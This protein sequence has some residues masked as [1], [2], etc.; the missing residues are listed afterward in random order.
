M[1]NRISSKLGILLAV[2]GVFILTDRGAAQTET[3][4]YNFSASSGA[5]PTG[6]SFDS[7]GNLYGTTIGEGSHDFGTVFSLAPDSSGGWTETALYRFTG[8]EDGR[9]PQPRLAFDSAGNIYGVTKQGGVVSHAC[10]FYGCGVVFRL[11]PSTNGW[12]YSVLYTFLG[13][14]DGGDPNPGL[15]LDR[16][17]NIYGSTGSGGDDGGGVVFELSP[18]AHS[19]WRETPIYAGVPGAQFPSNILL[20]TDGE[21]YGITSGGSATYGY[22][23]VFKLVPNSGQWEFDVLYAFDAPPASS[24]PDSLFRDGDGN[25]YGHTDLGGGPFRDGT[26]YK[27]SQAGDGAWQLSPLYAFECCSPVSISLSPSGTIYGTSSWG[28]DLDHCIAGFGCGGIWELSSGAT[29]WKFS[30]LYG[31][32]GKSG[33]GPLGTPVFD[34]S[35]N[36]YGTTSIGGTY[37]L[38]VAYELQLTP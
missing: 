8:G 25:L 10:E 2:V 35:G 33:W 31:F 3:V 29:D 5:G 18:T 27:L 19:K 14:A 28:G 23:E 9:Y 20:G 36:L 38:G 16:A 1:K 22:G 30:W 34:S 21:L 24:E 37:G 11:S 26:V 15:V 12:V 7:K 13:L 4:L 17:G 32:D 6:L